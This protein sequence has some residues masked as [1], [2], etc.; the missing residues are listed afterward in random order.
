[1]VQFAATNANLNLPNFMNGA[2]QGEM[3]M[4]VKSASDQLGT[5]YASWQFGSANG[6]GGYPNSNGHVVEG[7]GSNTFL[8]TGRPAVA[9]NNFHVYNV[10]ASAGLWVN[11]FD[12]TVNYQTTVNTVGFNGGPQIG[13]TGF[14]TFF[15]EIAEILVYDHVLTDQ[16]RSVVNSYLTFKY[17]SLVDSNGDGIPD[18]QAIALGLNPFATDTDGDG[19]PDA[20]EIKYGLN[21]LVPDA[22]SSLSGDGVSNFTKYQLGLDPTKSVD[23]DPAAPVQLRVYTPQR[24]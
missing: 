19:I 5:G 22:N 23:A 21:P 9:L 2:T 10:S 4:I 1:V 12:G 14:Q 15:G 11:R 20:W 6:A 3:F 8:D 16:E 7:F 18:A 17:L 13:R 24:N